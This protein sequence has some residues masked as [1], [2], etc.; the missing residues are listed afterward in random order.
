MSIEVY[1][2]RH[3]LSCTNYISAYKGPHLQFERVFYK[4]PPLIHTGR[5]HAEMVGQL[6]A[7]DVDVVFSSTLRRAQE[8]AHALYPRHKVIIAPFLKEK[9]RGPSNNPCKHLRCTYCDYSFVR[10]GRFKKFANSSNIHKFWTVFLP[11]F[12]QGRTKP[13]KIAVVT[14][15]LLMRRDLGRQGLQQ[16]PHNLAIVSQH[17]PGPIRRLNSF[18]EG[19][20]IIF[21]GIDRRKLRLADL[22]ATNCQFITAT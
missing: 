13:L 8:T 11:Y 6:W 5:L 7:P 9:A 21:A 15:S 19:K 17:Y 16:K 12:L 2:I 14:H 3:G 18:R 20:R 1:F 22:D 4:D 10:S